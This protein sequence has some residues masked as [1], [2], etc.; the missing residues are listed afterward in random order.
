MGEGLVYPNLISYI[1]NLSVNY[2]RMLRLRFNL[3][4]IIRRIIRLAGFTTPGFFCILTISLVAIKICMMRS[5]RVSRVIDSQTRSVLAWRV[6]RN[7]KTPTQALGS[8]GSGRNR[9]Y[10]R[11][12]SNRTHYSARWSMSHFLPVFAKGENSVYRVFAIIS[13]LIHRQIILFIVPA[14]NYLIHMHH[15]GSNTSYN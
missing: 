5:R 4:Q 6:A 3:R 11:R 7:L 8:G 13:T 2:P 10:Q 14:D 1:S 12:A 9:A 15:E